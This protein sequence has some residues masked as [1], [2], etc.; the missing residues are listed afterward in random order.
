MKGFTYP[1]LKAPKK[2]QLFATKDLEEF[3]FHFLINQIDNPNTNALYWIGFKEQ[4]PQV[5]VPAYGAIDLYKGRLDAYNNL[6]VH[7]PL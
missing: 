2:D 7:Q 1:L 4:H 5:A 3:Y 6:K